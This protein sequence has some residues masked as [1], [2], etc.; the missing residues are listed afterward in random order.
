MP[1]PLTSNRDDLD[2]EAFRIDLE[3]VETT[4]ARQLTA[5]PSSPDDPV[6]ALYRAR[7]E[8]LLE[9][10]RAARRR[11]DAGRFGL[12]VECGDHIPVGRLDLRPWT[13]M[14]V[15]CARR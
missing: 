1:H 12:C 6:A 4:R 14:C 11:L 7:V 13:A 3:I 2:L 15:R 8:L 9:E 10:I 5:L